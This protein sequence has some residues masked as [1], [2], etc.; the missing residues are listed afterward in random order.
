MSQLPCSFLLIRVECLSSRAQ[1]HAQDQGN[2]PGNGQ[3]PGN[4]HDDDHHHHPMQIPSNVSAPVLIS[5]D[6]C[7]MSQLPCSVPMPMQ[8]PSNVSAPVLI[9]VDLCLMS[10]LP[11]SVLIQLWSDGA[12]IHNQYNTLVQWKELQVF[13]RQEHYSV[14]QYITL[15]K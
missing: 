7:R 5:V 3:V 9:Y 11:C 2:L 1:A 6:L 12:D 8:I 13:L 14:H 4:H 10:Q 15:V